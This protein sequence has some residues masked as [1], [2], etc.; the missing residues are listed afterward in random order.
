M[1]AP[2][3]T[4]GLGELAAL[5][6]RAKRQLAMERA[7]PDDVDFIVSRLDEIEARIIEMWEEGEPNDG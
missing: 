1:A 5:R 3:K 6:K 4:A 7:R 2:L